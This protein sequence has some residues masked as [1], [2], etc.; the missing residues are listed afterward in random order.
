MD[1]TIAI[2]NHLPE[3]AAGKKHP[4]F[5]SYVEG[6]RAYFF[7]KRV[8]DLCL[9]ALMIVFIFSWLFPLLALLLRLDSQGPVFFLQKRVGKG[10][11]SFTCYK[12]RTM[13]VNQEAHDRQATKND[14]RIT[15][16]GKLL[17]TTNI[18]ELPQFFNV[19]LGHMS[20]VG[21][22]PHMYAD[23]RQFGEVIPRYKLR[24]LVKPGITGMAQVNGYHGPVPDYNQAYMR[25][26]WDIFYVCNAGAWLDTRI[27]LKTVLQH[28]RLLL[29]R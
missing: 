12:F 29:P 24:N 15:K 13:V 21:P 23:C 16:L 1:T 22:R 27:M 18:D 26:R 4:S 5:R 11:R 14:A 20:I 7:F 10:G 25:Y 8:T 9:S 17:R 19:L 2:F 6:K 28:L 3:I